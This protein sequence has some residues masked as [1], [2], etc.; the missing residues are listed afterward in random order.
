MAQIVSKFLQSGKEANK[1]KQSNLGEDLLMRRTV[2]AEIPKALT[3]VPTTSIYEPSGTKKYADVITSLPSQDNVFII[4]A[5]G[6]SMTKDVR[7]TAYVNNNYA[8]DDYVD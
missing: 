3:A 8:G 6:A 4:K 2:T 7:E 5:P 1:P